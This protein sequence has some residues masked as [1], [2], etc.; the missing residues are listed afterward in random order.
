MKNTEAFSAIPTECKRIE[1]GPWVQL[2]AYSVVEYQA[3]PS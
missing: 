2:W 3:E 1:F